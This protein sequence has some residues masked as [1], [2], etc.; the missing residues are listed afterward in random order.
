MSLLLV[1]KS[2]YVCTGCGWFGTARALGL[3]AR[4]KGS[5][6][7]NN[8]ASRRPDCPFRPCL[9]LERTPGQSCKQDAAAYLERC[10]REQRRMGMPPTGGCA[11]CMPTPEGRDEGDQWVVVQI[12][13]GKA[14]GETFEHLNHNGRYTMTVTVPEGAK[15]GETLGTPSGNKRRRSAR[16][17]QARAETQ[18]VTVERATAER[19]AAERAAAERATAERAAAERTAAKHTDAAL[20]AADAKRLA[21]EIAAQ[22][23]AHSVAGE[24]AQVQGGGPTGE[25][26]GTAGGGEGEDARVE[27][28]GAAAAG[29]GGGGATS[30]SAH[31]GG[32]SAQ[33]GGYASFAILGDLQP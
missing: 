28:E 31:G 10:T 1:Q 14:P 30:T 16:E 2:L 21:A 33:G 18:A 25:G 24:P 12:P 27:G 3:K 29:E 7:S 20:A 4:T 26:E 15:A 8:H 23:D 17:M 32:E 6:S 9:V 19:A 11:S 5:T 13:E 22:S